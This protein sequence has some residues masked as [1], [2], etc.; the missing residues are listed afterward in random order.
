M[1]IVMI[2]SHLVGKT[3]EDSGHLAI[4]HP[5]QLLGEHLTHLIYFHHIFDGGIC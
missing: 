1:I 2:G 4:G 5:V 3:R